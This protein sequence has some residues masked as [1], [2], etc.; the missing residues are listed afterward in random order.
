MPA[1]KAPVKLSSATAKKPV[2]KHVQEVISRRCEDC[3]QEGRPLPKV[4]THPSRN[5]KYCILHHQLRQ[6]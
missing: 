5:P 1:K 4:A 6:H 2:K 3:L